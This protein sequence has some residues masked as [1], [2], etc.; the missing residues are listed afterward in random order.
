V[1]VEHARHALFLRAFVDRVELTDGTQ[2]I[3]THRR[4]YGREEDV[5]D[6]L[7]YLP[8]LRERPG[9]LD[10]AKAFRG[11]PHPPALD[12][13]RVVLEDR[14]PSRI[15][16]LHFIEAVN[17]SLEVLDLARTHPLEEVAAAVDR[18]LATGS[19]VPATVTYFLRVHHTATA[20][21]S[22]VL[23]AT[24]PTCP[25]VQDRDLRQYNL[26]LTR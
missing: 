23:L 11:W 26:L 13:Y 22:P 15:A 4:C 18:A 25:S 5:L 7:H 21:P 12:R 20:S 19:V 24:A 10:H 2:A 17:A 6:P 16:T 8:L 1:P 9:A 3:A 14:L